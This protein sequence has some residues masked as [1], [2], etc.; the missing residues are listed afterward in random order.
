MAVYHSNKSSP[1]PGKE[2]ARAFAYSKLKRSALYN[3]YHI[4]IASRECGDIRFL[5]NM[6]VPRK[7]IIACDIDVLAREAAKRLGVIVSP[8]PDIVDTVAWANDNYGRS[9]IGSVNV[10]LCETL[11]CGLETLGRVFDAD[12]RGL[13]FFTFLRS[14]DRMRST[15]ERLQ[16][17][18]VALPN[19]LDHYAYQSYTADSIGSPMSVVVY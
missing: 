7:R 3:S 2:A 13:V 4:V 14:R 18:D 15:E 1:S 17:L 16:Y 10:D 5:L 11:P 6:G 12:V 9:N 19:R 8:F